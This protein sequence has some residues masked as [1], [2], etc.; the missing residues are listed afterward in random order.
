MFVRSK[1][2][3]GKKRRY[4]AESYRDKTTGKI[5]QRHIAYV[6]LWPKKD[7]AKLIRMVKKYQEHWANSE[8]PEHA[9]AFRR[10]ALDKAVTLD[11]AIAKFKRTMRINLTPARNRVDGRRMDNDTGIRHLQHAHIPKNPYSEFIGL[12]MRVDSKVRD[13]E[14]EA[15]MISW[16][17]DRLEGFVRASKFIHD[18]R[19]E[20]L[21]LINEKIKK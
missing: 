17:D 11:K 9:K 14:N 3:D 20:A 7:I 13:L 15:R 16:S 10:V 12:I 4:L 21:R 1:I 18:K 5:R 6:D 2:I 8:R 19:E